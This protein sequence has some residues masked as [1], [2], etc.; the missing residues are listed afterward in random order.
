MKKGWHKREEEKETGNCHKTNG[1]SHASCHIVA[2]K[3]AMVW[4]SVAALSLLLLRCHP[5]YSAAG[6][7][8]HCCPSLYSSLHVLFPPCH[9]CSFLLLALHRLMEW[10]LW[11]SLMLFMAHICSLQWV[12]QRGAASWLAHCEHSI[13][14]TG[15]HKLSDNSWFWIAWCDYS[16]LAIRAVVCHCGHNSPG[17]RMLSSYQ[18]TGLLW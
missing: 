3:R 2:L 15:I 8:V 17:S 4:F 5:L 6:C 13:Y 12:Y 7:K 11:P 9:S 10:I 16:R 14:L 18:H 1:S